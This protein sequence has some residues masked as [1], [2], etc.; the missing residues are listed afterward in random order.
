MPSLIDLP[1]LPIRLYRNAGG[2]IGEYQEQ[3]ITIWDMDLVPD[4]VTPDPDNSAH[5]AYRLD[6]TGMTLSFKV[7]ATL[8]ST[9]YITE[10]TKAT[11]TKITHAVP[12]TGST[13]GQASMIFEE[14]EVAPQALPQLVHQLWI[15]DG[16]S[17][18]RPV[19][20]PSPLYI[21]LGV[22]P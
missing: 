4:G 22:G 14:T 21:P 18:P 12:Q 3:K 6:L 16:A 5:D 2:G 17:N 11:G 1:L 9:T 15:T 7:K 10:F 13:K 19:C 8:E 20:R